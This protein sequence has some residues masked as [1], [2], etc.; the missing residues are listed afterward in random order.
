MTIQDAS[1]KTPAKS[2]HDLSGEGFE[3]QSRPLPALSQPQIAKMDLR[4][5]THSASTLFVR[6]TPVGLLAVTALV[7]A[8]LLSTRALVGTAIRESK[9]GPLSRSK[10]G[11]AQGA[12]RK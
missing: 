1:E 2:N 3:E 6:V 4:L 12:A 5:G 10:G 7:S 11:H 8:I 9:A